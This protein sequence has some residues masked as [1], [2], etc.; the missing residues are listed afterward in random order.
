MQ[1]RHTALDLRDIN[2]DIFKYLFKNKIYFKIY[3]NIYFIFNIIKAKII[4]YLQYF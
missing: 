3:L 4:K 1:M 2:R